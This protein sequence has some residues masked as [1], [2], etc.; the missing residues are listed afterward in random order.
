MDFGVDTHKKMHMVV[1]LDERGRVRGR[2]TVPNTPEGWV[3]AFTW[4]CGLSAERLWGVENS[5]S[6]GKGFAQFL[7]S[8]SEGTVCEVSPQRTAQ[9]RRR[10]P[11]QD[12]TDETDALAIARLLQAEGTSL[13]TIAAD[14]EST[15]LR[16][17]SDHRD[18]L[19]GE[20]TRLINQL[21]GHML[22]I[23]PSYKESSGP[24]TK[25]SGILYCRDLAVSDATPLVQTRLLIIHQ[26]AEQILSVQQAIAAVTTQLMQRIESLQTPLMAVKGVGVVVAARVLGE[27]GTRPRISS[28]AALAAL[29]GAAPIAVSSAGQGGFRVN[30]GGNRQLNR[31]L[32]VIALTQRRCEPRAQA[33]YAKKCAEGKTPRA[34]MRC[35]KR[36]LV[37]VIYRALHDDPAPAAQ[38]PASPEAPPSHVAATS[39]GAAA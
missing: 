33:Y 39:G 30:H 6:L 22:Q 25:E 11:T 7:L 34:A 24:L 26:L 2:Q 4:A 13:P 37:D 35:L 21:H 12:K 18:N 29:S 5:G 9:Y 20:R 23:D 17:L 31:A 1:A 15:E 19:L 10:G 14:D 3:T 28:A 36:R 27:I 32:H 8:R 16:I 38:A